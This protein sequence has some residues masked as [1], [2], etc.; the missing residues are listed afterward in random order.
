MLSEMRQRKTNSA[1]Y[2]TCG[3]KKEEL[4]SKRVEWQLSGS[5][6]WGNWERLSV[7]R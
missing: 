1:R 2:N 5:K 4:N 6:R 3:I 7:I